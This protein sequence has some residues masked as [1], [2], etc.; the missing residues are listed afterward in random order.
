M[1]HRT[2]RRRSSVAAAAYRA[3]Q[4][5]LEERT[6]IVDDYTKKL[7]VEHAEIL[8]PEGAPDWVYDRDVLWNTT[9]KL[10]RRK[11]SQLARDVELGLP[12]E[13]DKASQLALLRE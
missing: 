3:G 9:E 6:G 13:L 7:G 11:D 12:I 1:A 4:K 10:E 8:A 2:A 5:L